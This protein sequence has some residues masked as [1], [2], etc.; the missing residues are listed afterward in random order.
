[1]Q[2]LSDESIEQQTHIDNL[3][4]TYQNHCSSIR[5]L[6]W[7]EKALWRRVTL[8]QRSTPEASSFEKLSFRVLQKVLQLKI[9]FTSS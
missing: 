6:R 1:M 4:K 5:E 3:N 2:K 9:A 8:R 7:K